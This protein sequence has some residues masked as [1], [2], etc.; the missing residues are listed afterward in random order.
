MPG[1]VERGRDRRSGAHRGGSGRK[2]QVGN[3]RAEDV[4]EA[5]VGRDAR[6]QVRIEGADSARLLRPEQVPDAESIGLVADEPQAREIVLVEL[7]DAFVRSHVVEDHVDRIVARRLR[8]E[9]VE[10]GHHARCSGQRVDV[11]DAVE[12]ERIAEALRGLRGARRGRGGD[13]EQE[14]R[15]QGRCRHAQATG[16]LQRSH[17]W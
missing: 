3:R 6:T 13:A 7:E 17:G 9:A 12:A 4:D 5:A 14:Q 10:A 1:V 16:R 8:E 11:D 15:R 2:R